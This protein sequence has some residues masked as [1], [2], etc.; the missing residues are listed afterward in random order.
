MR[1][2]AFMNTRRRLTVATGRVEDEHTPDAIRARLARGPTRSRLRDF[3]YG[4]ID[5]IVTTFAVVA[6]VAGAGLEVRVVLIL[7]AANLAADGFSMA[8][9]N[10]LGAKSD[11]Q[12]RQRSRRQEEQHI[13]VVPAGEREEVRQILTGWGLDKELLEGVVDA[14]TREPDRWIRLMMQLEH[15]FSPSRIS[16]ARAALATFV[17]FVTV[18]FVPLVP[19]VIDALPQVTVTSAFGWSTAMTGIAF[20]AVG[21]GKGIV[22]AQSWWRSGLETLLVGG[23]AAMLAY[24]VGTGLGGFA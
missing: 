21:V 3:V 1:P 13:A 16:P 14:V 22:V 23:A 20:L 19:F 15:G 17:A 2:D 24:A 8:A 9:S 4:A 7:G 18:G 5:G 11:E 6:G 12:R 10:F